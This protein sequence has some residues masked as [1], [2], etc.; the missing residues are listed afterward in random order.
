MTALWFLAILFLVS[1]NA[2]FVAAE[3]ALVA[4]RPSRVREL[5]E[6]GN[7]AARAVRQLQQDLNHVLSGVQLGI[8]LASLGLG[9]LG[10]VTF[11]RLV[12]QGLPWLPCGEVRAVSTVL[13]A[14][15][16]FAVL[17]FLH[18]VLG[19]LVPR[20]LSLHRSER[21]ALLVARPLLWYVRAFRWPILLLDAA[22]RR[23]VKL[24]GVPRAEG[25]ALGHSP[26]ELF[27]L[28]EQAREHGLLGARGE[29]L[30]ESAIELGTVQV[31]EV[32]VA[33]PDL[34]VLS[35]DASLDEVLRAFGTT[36]RS[37]IPVYQATVDQ[38]LG[39]VHIKD[40]FWLLLERERRAEEGRPAA[41]FALRRLLREV[42]IVPETK[43]LSELL[44]ELRTRRTGLAMVVDEYGSISGMVTLE[45]ILEQLVGEIHDEFDMVERPQTLADGAMVFDAALKLR[46]LASD[47]QIDLPDDVAYETLGGFVLSQLGFIPRGGESFEWRS[48]RFTV[49]EMDRRRVAGVKIERVKPVGTLADTPAETLERGGEGN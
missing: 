9:Y 21:L 40:V 17:A 48:Y 25:H 26:E 1:L 16:S 15:L 41:P 30:I 22:S 23:F 37:R 29:R 14:A 36:Q 34:H 8:T 39:F 12:G 7:A 19:E 44:I 47:Y 46:D 32:M 28:A 43:P 45:D 27:I 24:L 18:V 42:L 33:R 31:R 3:F 6:A 49:L 10:L 20:G 38:I 11:S 13:A 35:A 4:V 5:T 2:F